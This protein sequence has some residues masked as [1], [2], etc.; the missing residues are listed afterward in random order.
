ML[1]LCREGFTAQAAWELSDS[2][3]VKPSKRGLAPREDSWE[4]VATAG[5]R[6]AVKTVLPAWEGTAA[7][8][9]P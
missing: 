7:E 5:H 4:V 6:K 8:M 9:A 3:Q 2:S 1:Q